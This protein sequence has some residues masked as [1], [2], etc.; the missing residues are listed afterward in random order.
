MMG[1]N[2]FNLTPRAK[3]VYKCAKQFAVDNAHKGINNAHILYGCLQNLS[4][5][6]IISLEISEINIDSINHEELLVG[7]F[8][9]YPQDFVNDFEIESWDR[10]T[11]DVICYAQKL[12]EIYEHD[13]IGIE[14]LFYSILENSEQ[15]CSFLSSKEIDVDFLKA[16][17]KSRIECVT[18]DPRKE[19]QKTQE[20]AELNNH[21]SDE[22]KNNP[23]SLYCSFLNLKAANGDFNFISERDREIDEVIEIISKKTKSNAILIG[24]A[25]VGK[26]AIIEGLAQRIVSQEVPINL[27][28]LKIYSV[29][30]ASMVAGT[31]YRGEFEQKL[32]S[33]INEAAQDQNVILFFDEIHNI[34]GAG[35]S[36][37]SLDA[38][39]ILKPALARG[40]F[41]C[42]GATTTQEYKKYFEK[43]GAIK[44]RFDTVVINAPSKEQTKKM[45]ENCVG[46]YEEFHNAIYKPQ[47]ID[48]IIQLCD[49]HIPH[50][51]FPDKA[52]DIIDLVGAQAKIK[53]FQMPNKIKNLQ[54]ELKKILKETDN[55]D[56]EENYE[57]CQ[58]LLT[59]YIIQLKT[60]HE[61]L[62]T[63]KFP[64]KTSDVFRIISEKTGLSK[65]SISVDSNEF[66]NFQIDIGKEVFGQSEN[67]AKITDIL[68]CA[69]VGLN[70]PN[71]PL[72]SLFFVGPTSVGKTH[73]AK[74][75]AKHFYGNEKAIIQINMSEY[76]D[77]TGMSK[78]IG[79]SA[80]YVGFEQGGLLTEFVRNNPN[81]VVLFDEVEKCDPEILNLLLHLLDEGYVNDNLNNKISFTRC[82]VILTS[83]I[84]SKNAEQSSIGFINDRADKEKLYKEE[85][86]KYLKPEFVARINSIVVF[87]ELKDREF[88][89]IIGFEISTIQEK[90]KKQNIN[91]DFDEEIVNFILNSL[92]SEKLHARSVKDVVKDKLHVPISKFIIQNSQKSNI[93]AKVIDN[94]INI[95]YSY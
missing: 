12:S 90:L 32:K 74:K 3:K 54:L 75:I 36:E 61:K 95:G 5:D 37:G 41:K 68:S 85:V 8:K 20:E 71:K 56:E 35:S 16:L 91:I 14:H 48:L 38:S 87:N 30:L 15:I 64:I 24:E 63:K 44:R 92:K 23:L 10:E 29:D 57:Q 67:L 76:Q 21:A 42:I 34:V 77:K 83:N 62:L 79:A 33:L 18:A 40:N 80:G 51:N 69:K 7:Y 73:T 55:L 84:G 22:K 66:V 72:A 31:R 88:E 46:S 4:E 53:N 58:D 86:K 49:K 19:P 25:G 28:N 60:F 78:L 1:I 93:S 89:Q 26:T 13:Y 2:N 45:I 65:D 43:D 94:S 47:I 11:N 17:I 81:C 27:L 50:K 6:L 59:Q 39:N 52:F 70:D 82:V 9:A